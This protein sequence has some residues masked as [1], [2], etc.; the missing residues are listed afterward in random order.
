[1]VKSVKLSAHRRRRR[2]RTATDGLLPV[3]LIAAF[4]PVAWGQEGGAGARVARDEFRLNDTTMVLRGVTADGASIQVKKYVDGQWVASPVYDVKV[5]GR[6]G[7]KLVETRQ[8]AKGVEQVE[9]DFSTGNS[10]VDI[11]PLVSRGE[12]HRVRIA[13]LDENGR[14]VGEREEERKV[15]RSAAK[16]IYEDRRGLARELWRAS[17]PPPPPWG[18]AQQN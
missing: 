2:L 4:A 12:V 14:V 10:L 9:T 7:G 15:T 11:L 5:G 1:M 8:T 16:V 18:T 6:I 13:E 17:L 3:L